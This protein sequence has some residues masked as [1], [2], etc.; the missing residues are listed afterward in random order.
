MDNVGRVK[1]VCWGGRCCQGRPTLARR[2]RIRDEETEAAL[3]RTGTFSRPCQEVTDNLKAILAAKL[4]FDSFA[5]CEKAS[6]YDTEFSE[7]EFWNLK[8]RCWTRLNVFLFWLR[9]SR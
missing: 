4:K 9:G 1:A 5:P 7:N 8:Y 6:S 2:M 3:N